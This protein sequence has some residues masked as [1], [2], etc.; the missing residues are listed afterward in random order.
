MCTSPTK[1]VGFGKEVSLTGFF[2]KKISDRKARLFGCVC[3]RRFWH[4]LDEEHCRRLVDYARSFGSLDGRELAEPPLDS[5]HKAVELAEKS[6][7]EVVSPD[8][9]DA[10]SGAISALQYPASDYCACYGE[11]VGPFD[12][13]F[14]ASGEAAEA[15][16]HASSMKVNVVF[17]GRMEAFDS[18][19]LVVD[20]TTKAAGY[21]RC[22]PKGTPS[23]E[24][25]ADERTAHCVL[26]R[27]IVGNPFRPV[28]I[29]PAW[30]TPTVVA[31]AQAAYDN[32]ILPAGTLE[33]AR[34]AVLADA[35]EEA[36]CDNA[37]ILTHLRQAGEHV[38]G[39]WPI[40]LLLGRG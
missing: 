2:Q 32:R 18:L 37:D 29:N 15:V 30:Q 27:D 13:E 28:P 20:W 7:D 26:L 16:H 22:T 23:E 11:E 17:G 36:G 38:R 4:L 6:A 40:D 1:T 25:A 8:E 5:C 31:L 3:C 12:G 33:P 10:L 24:S 34:L 35:L 14:V 39:C 9:L 19:Q 21:Y